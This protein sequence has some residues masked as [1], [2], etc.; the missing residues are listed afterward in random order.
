[1]N[2]IDVSYQQEF[3][4]NLLIAGQQVAARLLQTV[5]IDKMASAVKYFERLAPFAPPKQKTG[6]FQDLE[7]QDPNYSRRI[8]VPQDWDLPTYVD[9]SDRLRLAIDPSSAQMKALMASFNR[10]FDQTII[11][12]A[13]G[14]SQGYAQAGQALQN[15]NPLGGNTIAVNYVET[16]AAANANMTVG[17]LKKARQLLESSEQIAEGEI[18]N[19]IYNSSNK[20][21][22]LRDQQVTNIF[23]SNQKPLVTGT[24]YD[25]FLGMRF[26]RSELLPVNGNN[27]TALVYP[28]SAIGF[29][30]LKEFAGRIDE[31]TDKKFMPIQLYGSA[32]WGV[33]RLW[34]EKVI[35]ILCD[36]TL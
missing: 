9:T 4:S 15:Y 27:V 16:G 34:E 5:T 20:M 8:V 25:D 1:M 14:V 26:I 13:V 28:N 10:Q 23:Y 31:R 17:K 18:L 2:N 7:M 29:C 11:S 32:S 22:L 24:L 6:R 36:Q 33:T 19:V 21:A 30:W 35:Q 3:S 12:A